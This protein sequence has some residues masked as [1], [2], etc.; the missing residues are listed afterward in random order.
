[1]QRGFIDPN[2]FD[3]SVL[4]MRDMADL[5]KGNFYATFHVSTIGLPTLSDPY[6]LQVY[7][8]YNNDT[9]E[10]LS[11]GP[12]LSN[13]TIFTYNTAAPVQCF[14]QYYAQNK[15]CAIACPV[16]N[17]QG[18]LRRYYFNDTT[19]SATTLLDITA[20]E[21]KAWTRPWWIK[22]Q[23]L[24]DVYFTPAF[25]G[26]LFS[27]VQAISFPIYNTSN[28]WV[29][30][31]GFFS[32]IYSLSVVLDSLQGVSTN[33]TLS[34]LQ[35]PEGGVLGMSGLGGVENFLTAYRRRSK[36]YGTFPR[37]SIPFSTFRR[38]RSLAIP[39]GINLQGSRMPSLLLKTICSR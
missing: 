18:R 4:F 23:R 37:A 34:Y 14:I 29:A 24:G 17:T 13:S 7:I 8:I 12:I 33:N 39:R 36:Q 21:Y 19:Q 28:Q 3:N 30:G 20:T 2:D 35:S 27:I 31:G 38:P 11:I 22:N 6:F 1:M 5:V 9:M 26:S 16:A 25:V 10:Q 32:S 15:T